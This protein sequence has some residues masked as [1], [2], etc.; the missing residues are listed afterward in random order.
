MMSNSFAQ[1]R[2][3]FSQSTVTILK[4]ALLQSF[5]IIEDSRENCQ[6]SVE[7]KL[8]ILLALFKFFA[9]IFQP[10]GDKN[11]LVAKTLMKHYFL[12]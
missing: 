1:F 7:V 11:V 4:L 2:G 9:V 6:W 8:T 5:L 12:V 3:A 10:Y